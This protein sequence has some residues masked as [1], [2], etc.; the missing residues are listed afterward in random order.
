MSTKLRNNNAVDRKFC[1]SAFHREWESSRRQS[2]AASSIKIA[3]STTQIS[4]SLVNSV[5]RDKGKRHSR[6]KQNRRPFSSG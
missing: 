5:T 4:L 2:R 3:Y 6:P 1:L